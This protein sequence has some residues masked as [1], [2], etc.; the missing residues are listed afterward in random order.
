MIVLDTS[1]LVRFFTKDIGSKSLLVKELF[2]SN[3][4][5][6]I[7]DVVFCELEY[8]LLGKVY[9]SSREKVLEAF[10]FLVNKKNVV[11]SNELHK[12]VSLYEESK[13]DLAD[14]II[15][16]C[17]YNG[18]LASFDRNLCAI[19]FVTGYW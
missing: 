17:S 19:G 7:P 14:C 16:V 8:V 1:A 5:L 2:E 11:V 9:G 15:A 4:H 6:F 10:R 12:A 18:K 13:L 3:E